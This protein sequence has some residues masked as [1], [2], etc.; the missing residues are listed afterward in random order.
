MLR[1]VGGSLFVLACSLLILS[2]SHELS[3]SQAE[4]VRRRAESQPTTPQNKTAAPQKD[5][6]V[7]IPEIKGCSR[8]QVTFYKGKVLAF[9]RTAK[10]VA[11]T[12]RTEWE[13]TEE[14]VQDNSDNSIEFQL[15]GLSLKED[16]RKRIE[17]LLA[18]NP[19]Q[20]Q[21]TVWTCNPG[22]KEQIK[23]IDWDP[24]VAK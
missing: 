7:A 6:R 17:S 18:D 1:I 13:T 11:I 4:A 10:S 8:D 12:V 3:Q 20:V 21:V 15:K 22:G 5:S 23:I 19:E 16:D 14:L 9:N 2:C 24:P